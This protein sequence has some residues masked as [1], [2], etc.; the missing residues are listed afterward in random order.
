[1]RV[2]MSA[3]MMVLTHTVDNG[4]LCNECDQ[5]PVRGW[6][7]GQGREVRGEKGQ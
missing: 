4:H 1:M 5:L 7:G 2:G 3:G 6:C